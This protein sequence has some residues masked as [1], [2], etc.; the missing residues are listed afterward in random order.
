MPNAA[1]LWNQFNQGSVRPRA[2]RK[3][4]DRTDF[5]EA[6]YDMVSRALDEN[7]QNYYGIN[8]HGIGGVGKSSLLH[9]LEKELLGAEKDGQRQGWDPGA[10]ACDRARRKLAALGKKQRPVVLR[11]DF[12]DSSLNTQEDV[13]FRFRT[14]ILS[15]YGGAVFPL[16]DMAMHRLSQKYGKPLPPEE[17]KALLIDNP[18]LSFALDTV[19]DLAGIGLIIGAAKT[20]L[21]VSQGVSRH[22][23]ER[24]NSIRRANLEMA[25][26]SAPELAKRLPYYFC[27]DVNAMDLPLVCVY[28]DT[29]EKMVSRAEGAGSS[30]GFTEEWLRGES[31]LLY[32]LGNAVFA[33]AGRERLAWKE[34]VECRY[35][36]AL[37]RQDSIEFLDGCG[38]RDARLQEEIYRLTGGEPVYLDLCVDEYEG[39]KDR[40]KEPVPEDFGKNRERLVERQIRYVPVN[41][42]EAVFILSAM[43]RFTGRLYELLSEK[44]PQ[45]PRSG[46]TE[47]EILTHLTYIQEEDGGW[48]IQRSVADILSGMLPSATRDLVRETLFEIACRKFHS[49]GLEASDEVSLDALYVLFEMDGE[50]Y[51]SPRLAVAMT[52]RAKEEQK[53][54][55]F[56]SSAQWQL[57]GVKMWKCLGDDPGRLMESYCDLAEIFM[58]MGQEEQ[59]GNV[60][61]EGLAFFYNWEKEADWEEE[62]NLEEGFRLLKTCAR[63]Y[64]SSAATEKEAPAIWRRLLE[65]RYRLAPQE[66]RE[67]LETEYELAMYQEDCETRYRILEKLLEGFKQL[68]EENREQHPDTLLV[69]DS[70]QDACRG[71]Q[72]ELIQESLESVPKTDKKADRFG[73]RLEWLRKKEEK[74]EAGSSEEKVER[75]QREK[76][77]PEEEIQRWQMIRLKHCQEI[78]DWDF[79]FSRDEEQDRLDILE[80]WCCQT[81]AME[82]KELL[83]VC[84]QLYGVF[85]KNLGPLHPSTL[86]VGRN[87]VS[88]FVETIN[89]RQM[90][91]QALDGDKDSDVSK[92]INSMPD[93]ITY[94]F[95]LPGLFKDPEKLIRRCRVF[96]G[97][98]YEALGSGHPYI[99]E[100]K[101]P[102]ACIY[103]SCGR[104]DEAIACRRD[105]AEGYTGF[106]GRC[107]PQAAASQR[108]LVDL[109]LRT[110]RWEE[111]VFQ[112]KRLVKALKTVPD[113][114]EACHELERLCGILYALLNQEIQ[115]GTEAASVDIREYLQSFIQT[116]K[117]LVEI[118]GMLTDRKTACHGLKRLFDILCALIKKEKEPGK[119]SVDR[120]LQAFRQLSEFYG[121]TDQEVLDRERQL[122]DLLLESD[123]E[124]EG[125]VWQEHLIQG[126]RLIPNNEKAFGELEHLFDILIDRMKQE[127]QSDTASKTA[128]ETESKAGALTGEQRNYMDKLRPVFCQMSKLYND[129]SWQDSCSHWRI[130]NMKESYWKRTGELTVLLIRQGCR[131]EVALR[132]Q[133]AVETI[134][135]LTDKKE[136]SYGLQC[137]LDISYEQLKRETEPGKLSDEFG[138]IFYQLSDIYN[139]LYSGGCMEAFLNE[140]KWF[141]VLLKFGRTEEAVYQ[142]EHLAMMLTVKKWAST[143]AVREMENLYNLLDKLYKREQESGTAPL[144]GKDREYLDKLHQVGNLLKKSC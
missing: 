33:I 65:M 132:K 111:A 37:S 66:R 43:G 106:Y 83:S 73:E 68:D 35:I 44:I 9:Q 10:D 72:N 71:R 41:L 1:G 7:F 16:F 98:C 22:L 12:D 15:Q 91:D 138:R 58:D 130:S 144:S 86:K 92:I 18:V 55:H 133:Q 100:A 115:S 96:I 107:S 113:R 64:E 129:K 125:I 49:S 103:E 42:R 34:L 97:L 99:C 28:L 3:F 70:M 11:A 120:L 108:R 135:V 69:L 136:I 40:G 27:M 77:E 32:N 84:E 38:I 67:I 141:N 74:P 87:G 59:A 25:R 20:A 2:A 121:E 54:R 46:G 6:Y 95:I 139:E 75:V 57:R 60:C 109:F 116:S 82:E 81:T 123:R 131:E 102:L 31:G 126:Y 29:Y 114:T 142:L 122:I 26:M 104:Y 105:I 110:C 5:R 50:K 36:E 101:E 90:W 93:G 128:F 8:Y 88:I 21:Q 80:R 62:A 143:W 19:G 127:A 61:R 140:K 78:W 117:E 112:Q 24:K 30:T 137:L 13:L 85:K 56:A 23:L 134:A 52:D 45:L 14:Q 17:Q 118:E 119:E 94:D 39:L 47:Y 124:E 53:K 4:T 89:R 48:S 76:T 63:I 79:T 51:P